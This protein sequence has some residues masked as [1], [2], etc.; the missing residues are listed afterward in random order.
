MRSDFLVGASAA[1][2]DTLQ[3]DVVASYNPY[4]DKW[5]RALVA[6]RWSPQRLTTVALSYRY[7]REPEP[8]IAY[9]S[10]GQNQ[11]SLAVQWPFSKRWYGVGR[12]DYSMRTGLGTDSD[13][14]VVK[15]SP[16]VTQA[17]AGLE[18]KGDCCWV[19][20][21]VYQR[22]AVA[23]NDANTALFLQLELTGLGSLGTDPMNL[24]NR[25]I[26][27]YTSITPPVPSGTTF[28]RYE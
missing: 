6:A 5:T 3:T 22:Y 8:G 25:S 18:Y 27:G 9:Q 20:R 13:G 16:R 7:Q 11:V 24:L 17:I 2:T 1:L 10:L 19:G 4:D 12:V 28:E 21:I 23:A 15:E 26:P 14:N